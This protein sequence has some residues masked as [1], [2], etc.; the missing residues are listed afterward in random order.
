MVFKMRG[1]S[2]DGTKRTR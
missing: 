1:I 2:L